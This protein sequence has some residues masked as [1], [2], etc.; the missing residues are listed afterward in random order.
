MRQ[1]LHLLLED[2]SQ[3]KAP[4]CEGCDGPVEKNRPTVYV[5]GQQRALCLDCANALVEDAASRGNVATMSRIRERAT[6]PVVYLLLA[7]LLLQ[8]PW[9][10]SFLFGTREVVVRTECREPW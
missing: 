9:I 5:K 3:V 8:V 10:R 2:V 7:V 1:L 4:T 6:D